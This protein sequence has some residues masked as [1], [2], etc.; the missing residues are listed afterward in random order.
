[1]NDVRILNDCEFLY[2][3]KY[4]FDLCAPKKVCGP[5]EVISNILGYVNVPICLKKRHEII[6]TSCHYMEVYYLLGYIQA[7]FEKKLPVLEINDPA[8]KYRFM[9]ACEELFDETVREVNEWPNPIGGHMQLYM[10]KYWEEFEKLGECLKSNK[11][12]LDDVIEVFA[13]FRNPMLSHSDVMSEMVTLT[14]VKYSSE[15]FKKTAE[16]HR[17]IKNW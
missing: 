8:S 1:M 12:F 14:C 5:R 4:L 17:F 6:S 9:T 11:F 2:Q 15:W 13:S 10:F 16:S 7:V 3:N